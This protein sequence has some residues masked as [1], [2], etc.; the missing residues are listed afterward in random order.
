MQGLLTGPGGLPALDQRSIRRIAS[1]PTSR[2]NS[3][4]AQMGQLGQ[5]RTMDDLLRNPS[6]AQSVNTIDEM[7]ASSLCS[8]LFLRK[9]RLVM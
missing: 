9:V 2:H 4:H 1:D 7:V 6:L 5:M 8:C 3:R